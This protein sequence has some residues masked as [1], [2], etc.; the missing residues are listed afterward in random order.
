MENSNVLS[1][2]SGKSDCQTRVIIIGVIYQNA[3][4]KP[5][6]RPFI[7]A[8]FIQF[9]YLLVREDMNLPDII[10]RYEKYELP[11]IIKRYEKLT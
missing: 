2:K 5:Q 10:K 11:N 1:Q 9:I 8:K 4:F 7:L 3:F 6:K